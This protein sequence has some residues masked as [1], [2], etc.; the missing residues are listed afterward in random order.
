MTYPD[1]YYRRTMADHTVRPSLAGNVDCDTVIIGG[2]LAGLT[3]A[4]QLARGGQA[5]AVLE[6][7]SIGFGA[8]GRNGGFVSPGYAT[9]S[10]EIARI[11]GEDAARRLHLLSIEGMDFVRE[12]I[13]A[14]AIRDALPTRG[15]TSVLRY[16]DGASMKAHAEKMRRLYDYELDYLDRDQVRSVLKS[17]RYFQALRDRRAFHMHPLN[18]LRAL[19]GEI[20]R[21]GGLIYESSAVTKVV[22]DGAEKRVLTESGEVRARTV[23]FTTGGYTGSLHGRLKRAF[24]PIATYVMVSEEA[25]DLI[26][27]AIATADAIGDNRRAGDYYRVVDG[28]KRLLWGGRIT[29]RAAST[30][31]LVR[32]L[33]AEMVGTYPQLSGLK[34]ELA[35]SGLMSYARH[36][37]PQIGQMSPGV[38]YC[39]AFGGHG[40]NT[41]AIGGK[42]V[43]EGILG[44][45]ERYKFYQPFGLVWAGGLA[46]L[47]VAQLTYWKLQAQD[48][49]R[50]RAA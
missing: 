10:A 37:M 14:L 49:W 16:A 32:E 38:W 11:A 20:E 18:Y 6:A 28:G 24:L 34:T 8:S 4:L 43:A 5:V 40:L 26:A 9:G 25:P 33:R 47:A 46:G 21:L 19:A 17:D 48:W 31:A 23:V 3:T 30:D 29:T 7:E 42:V 12:T 41:T 27:S 22:L 35:W 1:S 39:T 36:L 50:E 2:G 45:S 13:E 44:Q 15:I